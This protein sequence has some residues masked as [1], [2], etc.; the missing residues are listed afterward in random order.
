M[1]LCVPR[2]RA[3][4]SAVHPS[5]GRA[6]CPSVP[7]VHPSGRTSG[8]PFGRP[9]GWRAIVVVVAM[10]L[11]SFSQLNIGRQRRRIGRMSE[12][13]PPSCASP[14]LRLGDS[15]SS[16]TGRRRPGSGSH[17]S[18][19][20]LLIPPPSGSWP[21]GFGSAT[22]S[23]CLWAHGPPA[24]G[25]PPPRHLPPPPLGSWPS[26][27]GSAAPPLWHWVRV[28]LACWPEQK[29]QLLNLF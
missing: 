4:R 17:P 29:W 2:L 25:P 9:A 1:S 5:I 8:R 14:L 22:S 21:S 18:P 11:C 28:P 12:E 23:L 13:S 26:G 7:S 10:S 15:S 16:G 20:W 27:L 3:V 6:V 19:F 24:S